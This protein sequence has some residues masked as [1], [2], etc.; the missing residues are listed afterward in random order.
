MKLMVYAFPANTSLSKMGP[1]I[2]DF[3]MLS[4][5]RKHSAFNVIFQKISN[6]TSKFP[7]LNKNFRINFEPS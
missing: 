6:K 3:S 4:S 5:P 7:L 2:A 1:S